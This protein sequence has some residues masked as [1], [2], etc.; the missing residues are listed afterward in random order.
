MKLPKAS[1]RVRIAVVKLARVEVDAG[2]VGRQPTVDV[3]CRIESVGA[4]AQF[5][6]YPVRVS[7]PK[8][9]Y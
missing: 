5:A 9:L 8:S 2:L 6:V 7:P 1:R 3:E 4:E